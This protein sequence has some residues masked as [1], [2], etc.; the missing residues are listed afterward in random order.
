MRALRELQKSFGDFL[1][2]EDSH[3]VCGDIVEDGFPAAERVRV[4]RNTFRGTLVA[5]LR[6]TYP[7]AERL[8]G[9]DFFDDAAGEFV[10][11]HP[12]RSGCL[13]QYGGEFAD[14]LGGFAPARAVL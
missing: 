5:S 7:A 11:A 13:D 4:Y 9:R 6:M 8:V 3:A 10:L 14:F 1:L 2:S 12:P